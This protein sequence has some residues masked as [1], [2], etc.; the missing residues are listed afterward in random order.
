M[1]DRLERRMVVG[2]RLERLVEQL[3]VFQLG[4]GQCVQ[5]ELGMVVVR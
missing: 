2:H 5:L 3:L 4:M 1:D